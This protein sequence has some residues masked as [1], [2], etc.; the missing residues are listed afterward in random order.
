[1]DKKQQYTIWY[2]VIAIL[3]MLI[4]QTY[5]AAT[6]EE[7]LSYDQFKALLKTGKIDDIAITDVAVTGVL[8]PDG[9]AGILSQQQ[10]DELK[11]VGEGKQ[12]RFATVRVAVTCSPA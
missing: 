2:F 12:H 3:L 4:G 7:D 6:H 5:F 10:L 8:K 9:L 11:S 1:M